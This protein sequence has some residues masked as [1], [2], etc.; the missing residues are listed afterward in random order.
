MID[1]SWRVERARSIA[2]GSWS[3]EQR[4]TNGVTRLMRH[5]VEHLDV[6]GHLPE[7]RLTLS[8]RLWIQ[9]FNTSEGQPEWTVFLPDQSW[10]T[11]IGGHLAH[12]T[13]NQVSSRRRPNGRSSLAERHAGLIDF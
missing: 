6:V 9:A 2:F 7:L 3:T 10:L 5:H 8:E 11:V 13:Q 1:W 4:M 12:N